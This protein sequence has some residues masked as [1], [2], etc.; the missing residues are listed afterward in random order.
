MKPERFMDLMRGHSIWKMARFYD[1]LMFRLPAVRQMEEHVRNGGKGYMYYWREPSAI[2]LRGACHAVELAYVSG[3][4][5][6]TIYTGANVNEELSRIA[7]AAW[8]QFAKT[9]D[10]STDELKW[11]PYSVEAH[12]PTMIMSAAPHIIGMKNI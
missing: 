10:P 1:E 12:R 2:P 7:M 5:D 11:E 8:V 3:N 9:G 4:T 6:Q